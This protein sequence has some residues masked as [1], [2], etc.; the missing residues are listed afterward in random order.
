M[1]RHDPATRSSGEL[2]RLIRDIEDRLG[3][4]RGYCELAKIKHESGEDL[5]RR[6]D[7]AIETVQEV[8]LLIHRLE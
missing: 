4:I 1:R 5:D 8:S 6:M 2:R 7:D 3:A